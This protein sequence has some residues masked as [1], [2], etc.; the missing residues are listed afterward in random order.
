MKEKKRIKILQVTVCIVSLMFL[1][2][3]NVSAKEMPT[4]VKND[5][6]EQPKIQIVKPG[7]QEIENH[8]CL[9]LE[10][11]SKYTGWFS[12]EGKTL[13]FD[14]NGYMQTSECVID[15]K[16]YQFLPTGEFVTGWQEITGKKYYRN[17]RGCICVGLQKIDGIDYYF[18]ENG[19][20]AVNQ[21]VGMYMADST[22]KLTRMPYTQENLNA[23]L[24]EILGETGTDI[25]AI[26]KYVKSKLKYKYIDKMS[27]R[28]E[29]A[30]Y[31]L[32][33]RRCSCYYYE[34]LCGLLLER[35]GYEV[36]TIQGKGRV[37]AEHYWSLV[38]TTRNGV[39]GWYHVDALN[40]KYVV[41]D[42]ELVSSG[43]V[44]NHA[45]YPA[46]P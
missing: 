26:G 38:K 31:A 17:E 5:E 4:T 44:W 22:G 14:R 9:I 12:S 21:V 3:V 15:G 24:D 16:L 1:C 37:Y 11:G 28:E 40:E 13:Y 45:N 35:A 25:T 36:I 34:A 19:Q 46:T 2:M 42:A 20:L 33:N 41:T 27:T 8:I 43:A 29:M 39:E 10:D 32:A 30:V 18:L 6:I 23:A 7:I